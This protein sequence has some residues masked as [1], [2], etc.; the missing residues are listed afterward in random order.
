MFELI[1]QLPLAAFSSELLAQLLVSGFVLG[2]AYALIAISFGV[3]YGTTRIFHLAHSFV[4]VGGAYGAALGIESLGLPLWLAVLLGLA[5]GVTVGIGIELVV[6]RSIRTAGATM[7]TLFLASLGVAVVGANLIQIAFGSQ[8][9]TL[10][11][12]PIE[13]IRL[14]PVRFTT[15]DVVAVSVAWIAVVALLVFLRR[16]RYGRAIDAVRIN[17]TMAQAVGISVNQVYL[18]VFAIGSLLVSIAAVL[19]TMDGVATPTVGLE[20]VLIGF[21]AVFLGGI[22]SLVGAALGGLTLGFAASLSGLWL[23]S[24]LQPAIVF[25][26]LFFVLILRPQGLLGRAAA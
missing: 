15:L 22:G 23:S 5:V 9:R 17:R 1:L 10:P 13:T 21:I 12:F 16:T 11:G 6:Y 18:L 14:G 20:P 25:G 24:D 19:A 26:V 3:I 7:L 2:S 8:N 4:Y